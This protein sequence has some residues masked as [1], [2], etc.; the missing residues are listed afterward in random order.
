M[1]YK[2][3]SYCVIEKG[4]KIGAGTEIGNFVELRKGTRIGKNCYIGSQTIIE[5]SVLKDNVSIQGMVRIG[6]RCI[7]HKEVEIKYQ[8]V[9][10]S[11]VIVDEGA[12]IGVNAVTLGSD[13]DGKQ[14][15]G[16]YIGKKVYLGGHCLVAPGI[17]IPDGTVIGANSYLREI[18]ETGVYVGTPARKIIDMNAKERYKLVF[19]P[20]RQETGLNKLAYNFIGRL[21]VKRM[22]VD[23]IFEFGC[24][25]GRHLLKFKELGYHPYGIDVNATCVFEARFINDLTCV[26]VG[27]EK[28][29]SEVPDDSFDLVFTNSVLCHIPRIRGLMKE[30]KRISKKHI[31]MVECDEKA[32]KH[33]YVHKYEGKKVLTRPSAHNGKLYSIYHLIV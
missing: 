31:V 27:D 20:Q 21:H 4:V 25:V 28:S 14:I 15:P 17:K 9:L 18:K 3:G 24:N 30:L 1:K 32:G 23:T 22:R 26:E 29:L 16:T 12:F 33:Y 2:T 8:A 7:I 11:D 10:T 5:G 6:S 13:V 19:H